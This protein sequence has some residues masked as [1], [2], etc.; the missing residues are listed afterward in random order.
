MMASENAMFCTMIPPRARRE[1][2]STWVGGEGL[3]P[4]GDV[5]GFDGDVGAHGAHGDADV[6]GGQRGG[7]SLMPS[8]TMAMGGGL[9][10]WFAVELLCPR[11][12]A[13]SA[14]S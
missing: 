4:S 8:P 5:G 13:R 11:E 7:A 2:A 9:V 10:Q 14:R 6:G 1:W 3:H 12:A